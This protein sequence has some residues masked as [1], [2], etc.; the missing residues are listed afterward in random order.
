M[1]RALFLAAALV[2]TAAAA[3]G[4]PGHQ[5]PNTP[6]WQAASVW[7]DRIAVTFADDPATTLTITWRT[8]ASV[9]FT[10]AQIVKASDDARFEAGALTDRART[11]IMDLERLPTDH[12]PHHSPY[13]VG[14]GVV[15][16]HSI[17]FEGLEPDTLYAWRVRG[18]EGLYSEW[19]Q[20]RTAPRSGPIEF[21]YFGDA[22]IG[23][24]SHW[25]RLIR[26]AEKAAPHAAF[27]LHAGDLVD[28]PDR[29]NEWAQWFEAGGFIHAQTPIMP[30]PG[31]HDTLRHNI[32]HPYGAWNRDLRGGERVSTPSPLWSAQFELPREEGLPR[33]LHEQAYDVRYSDD[34]HVFVVDSAMQPFDVQAQWLDAEL[35]AADARWTVVSMHHPFFTPDEFLT[36]GSERER[37]DLFL[38]LMRKH[39]V[40]LV[41]VGHYHG[42]L[43]GHDGP[44]RM[45]TREAEAREDGEVGTSYM[46]S[47]SGAA[48]ANLYPDAPAEAII[49]AQPG[50]NGEIGLA[51]IGE[52]TPLFQVIRIDGGQLVYEAHTATGRVYDAFTLNKDEAGVR[53]LVN[54]EAAFGETRLFSPAGQ[55]GVYRDL[56]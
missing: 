23:I 42:Y 47:F 37:R 19:F 38:P 40:D 9:G 50:G 25:S 46:I 39:D 13:N 22:Q 52:N 11:I 16:Y 32:D 55:R 7:P 26:M 12:G 17:T 51:R 4:H 54:G 8:D 18:S 28:R 21:V 44:P 15:A 20:T 1:T 34:L 35:A 14:L 3:W 27:F 29:D 10:H 6:P 33:E 48:S 31:N 41:L 53:R 36:R 56:D 49:A 43:R 5:H 24:R 30:V 2:F 45:T